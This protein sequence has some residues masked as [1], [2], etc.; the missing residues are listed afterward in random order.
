MGDLFEWFGR[1]ITVTNGHLF[2]V[3]VLGA[4]TAWAAFLLDG[5]I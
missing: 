3:F 2:A 1:P 4:L 5:L